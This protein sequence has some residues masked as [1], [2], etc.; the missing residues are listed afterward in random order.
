MR[1]L[2]L[3]ERRPRIVGKAALAR[4]VALA[5]GRRWEDLAL[6]VFRDTLSVAAEEL[7]E[8]RTTSLWPPI[9]GDAE[10]TAPQMYAE[11]VSRFLLS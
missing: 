9:V 3:Y 7:D 5:Q 1:E 8:P 10:A 6:T 4:L 2:T 11:A